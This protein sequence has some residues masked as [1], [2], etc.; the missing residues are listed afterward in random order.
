MA[1]LII[2]YCFLAF[3]VFGTFSVFA[4][5]AYEKNYIPNGSFENYRKK[6]GNIKNAIPWQQ[7]ASV[8]YY[9]SPLSNDTSLYKGART[10]D[11][12]AGMRYQKK[13]KEFLQVKLAEVM[14][15]YML[16][17]F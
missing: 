5:D 8:D 14:L 13:Y 6:S 12:Y 1:K 15:N 17:I 4:Q 7:I 11:C 2:K 10:G 16:T 3:Y 9:Q